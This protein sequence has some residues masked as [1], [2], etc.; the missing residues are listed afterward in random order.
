MP[1]PRNLRLTLAL[2]AL[3]VVS[4]VALVAWAYRPAAVLAVSGPDEAVVARDGA[5]AWTLNLPLDAER[6]AEAPLPTVE[7]AG[8]GNIAWRD[9]RTAVFTPQGGALPPATQLTVRFS[10]DLRGAGRFCFAD[11]AAPAFTVRTR[12]AV[13]VE[14]VAAMSPSFQAPVIALRLSRLPQDPTALL[15]A[16]AVSPEAAFTPQVSDG[17]LR[18]TGAF[19]PG[20]TYRIVIGTGGDGPAD[21]R[22][23]A[24][25]GEITIPPRRPGVRLVAGIGRQVEVEAVNLA[26]AVVENAAGQREVLRFAAGR[27]PLPAWLLRGGENRLRV[28]WP[29]GG[30]ELVLHRHDLPLTE[31]D[32]AAAL[33]HGSLPVIET[34]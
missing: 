8:L 27:A 16:V 10:G 29:D 4:T 34:R 7:P 28:T 19:V 6:L 18:L 15:R 13:A 31:A 22:P 11:G 21:D 32:G 17:E 3:W 23:A 30:D 33:L 9:A 25:S 24:W 14:Q 12:P 2:T 20:T 5:L 1:A 26:L